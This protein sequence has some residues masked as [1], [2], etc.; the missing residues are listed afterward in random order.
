VHTSDATFYL[1]WGAVLIAVTAQFA[2]YWSA[3]KEQRT[4]KRKIALTLGVVAVILGAIA[5][6]RA[7]IDWSHL[8]RSPEALQ[9]GQLYNNGGIPAIVQ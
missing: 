9:A 8:P 6:Y 1:F 5:A 3:A 7:A 2:N 4:R